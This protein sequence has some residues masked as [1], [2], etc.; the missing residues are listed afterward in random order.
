MKHMQSCG[1]RGAGQSA[2]IAVQEGQ[3]RWHV[4]AGSSTWTPELEVEGWMDRGAPYGMPLLQSLQFLLPH[5]LS[6][7]QWHPAWSTSHKSPTA[8]PLIQLAPSSTIC[9]DV[10]RKRVSCYI[11]TVSS[12]EHNHGNDKSSRKRPN[13][14]WLLID[15]HLILHAFS[16]SWQFK[17][18]WLSFPNSCFF[19]ELNSR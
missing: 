14:G 2:E 13:F 16:L 11:M 6:R 9:Q 10:R 1:H 18:S 15:F 17:A 12:Q 7:L 8:M 19:L 5:Q 4:L 3:L